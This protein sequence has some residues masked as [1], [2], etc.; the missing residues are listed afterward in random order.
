MLYK[1]NSCLS[2][3]DLLLRVL[4]V[5]AAAVAMLQLV[6]NVLLSRECSF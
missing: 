5:K 2:Y 3:I 4:V 6:E 1:T